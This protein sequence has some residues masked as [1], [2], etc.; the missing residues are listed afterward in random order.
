[1]PPHPLSI[2][3][4]RSVSERAPATPIYCR[5]LINWRSDSGRVSFVIGPKPMA[6]GG[7]GPVRTSTGGISGGPGSAAAAAP[8]AGGDVNVEDIR[9]TVSFPPAIKSAWPVA[10]AARWAASR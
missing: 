1:M 5:P 4:A 9:L 3:R 6:P 2:A 10:R 8:G 7:G